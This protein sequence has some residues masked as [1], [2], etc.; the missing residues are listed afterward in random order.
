MGRDAGAEKSA[1]HVV[2]ASPEGACI[3]AA[4]SGSTRNK[5]LRHPRE[6][7]VAGAL[8][9]PLS[10]EDRML[11]A[12]ML[13][14]RLRQGVHLPWFGQTF[15]RQALSSLLTAL[16]PHVDQG[17]VHVWRDS[18]EGNLAFMNA[19]GNIQE[20]L[21][22]E[23][24]VSEDVRMEQHESM[25]GRSEL[26]Q[27]DCH[28]NSPSDRVVLNARNETVATRDRSQIQHK[29]SLEV[30]DALSQ[31]QQWHQHSEGGLHVLTV[32]DGRECLALPTVESVMDG[33]CAIRVSLAD[34]EG[35]LLSNSIISDAFAALAA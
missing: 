31:S 29:R 12:L 13:L 28:F 4:E 18:D 15:G 22:P 35:L 19:Q 7:Y 34:P 6:G 21:K 16:R 2:V 30:V 10:V 25:A 1:G 5:I 8:Q 24:R 3:P 33:R 23:I 32:C 26:L 14:L 20:G 17:L 9:A 27:H 11:E